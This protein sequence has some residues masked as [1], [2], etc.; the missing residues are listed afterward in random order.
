MFDEKLSFMQ[1]KFDDSSLLAHNKINENQNPN[2]LN[3]DENSLESRLQNIRQGL[4][5]DYFSKNIQE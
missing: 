4:N 3:K 2:I 5:F 1:Q